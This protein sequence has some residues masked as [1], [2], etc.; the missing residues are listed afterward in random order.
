MLA[1]LNPKLR[2]KTVETVNNDLKIYPIQFNTESPFEAT[3]FHLQ[4]GGETP[5]DSHIEKECWL[6]LQGSGILTYENTP[7]PLSEQDIFY[8]DSYKKHQL[9]NTSQTIL[10][11]CSWYWQ[12]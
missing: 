2:F 11:I 6:V 8:F 12:D 3:F 4:P 9:F 7:Y 5:L 1:T 10:I